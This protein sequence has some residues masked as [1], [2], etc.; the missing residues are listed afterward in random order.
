MNTFNLPDDAVEF[1]R[2]GGQLKYDQRIE[3][4]DVKLKRLNE[5][6]LGEV[7]INTDM[8]GDPHSGKKGY[9]AVPA[10]SLTG[11]CSN[12]SPEFILLWLPNEK[13]FGTWDCDHW[14]LT[15]FRDA[16]WADIVASPTPYINAQWDVNHK[17]GTPFV[18]WPKYK[19]KAG[20]PF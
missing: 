19:F 14:L 13:L 16:S 15:V 6:A 9:Y 17:F 5:L 20:M 11:E 18:P 8:K 3:A 7:W 2:A 12:Y 1:F 4:R 10:V